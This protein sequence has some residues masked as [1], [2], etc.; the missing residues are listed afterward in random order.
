MTDPLHPGVVT[1]VRAALRGERSAG[2]LEQLR[3]A[4]SG[5]Y[6]TL[7]ETE[8]VRAQLVAVDPQ[9]LPGGA[10]FD[11]WCLTD[12]GTLEQWQ[13]DPRARKAIDA[14]WA[15]DPDPARTLTIH[16]QIQAALASGAIAPVTGMR[17]GSYFYCCPWSAIYRVRR[18]VKIDGKPLAV[19]QQFTFDVSGEELTEGGSF[20]RRILLGPFTPTSEVDYCDPAGGGHHDD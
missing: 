16:A 17:L 4:G 14:M 18:P 13:A 12:P 9:T 8:R 7:A 19:P 10:R 6:E 5:V 11:P 1:R 2:A 15:V 20:A 3:A